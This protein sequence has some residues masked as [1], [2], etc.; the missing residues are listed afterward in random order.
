MSS[1][2]NR[3]PNEHD[4]RILLQILQDMQNPIHLALYITG[5]FIKCYKK[6]FASNSRLAVLFYK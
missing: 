6:Y 1:S 4:E 2:T 5:Y 3:D